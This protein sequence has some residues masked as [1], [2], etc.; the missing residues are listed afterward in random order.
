MA[1]FHPVL[2]NLDLEGLVATYEKQWNEEALAYLETREIAE[3]TGAAFR[4]G[5][6]DSVI[7][8]AVQKA[9]ASGHL[10]GRIVFPVRDPQGKLLDLIGRSIDDREPKYKALL[11]VT[12]LL[13][14]APV[15]E[16]AEDVVLAGGL[17]DVLSL[18]Q[19][20]FPAVAVPDC[21]SFHKELVPLFTG[22][23]VFVCYG[24]DEEGRR[25]SERVA[26][27]LEDVADGVYVVTLP[28]GIKDINDLYVRAENAHEVFQSL[29]HRAVQTTHTSGMAPDAHYL[30]VY[31]EEYM[32]RFRGQTT[33][34]P[35]GLA[36]LDA[37]LIGGLRPGLYVIRG[38]VG[39][40]KTTLARQIAD[41]AAGNGCPVAFY[42]WG[43]SAYE[44]WANS[45]S[46]ILGVSVRDVLLGNL[47]PDQVKWANEQY[48][49]QAANMWTAEGTMN[50]T[51]DDITEHIQT[52]AGTI[53]KMP[54]VFLDYLQRIPFDTEQSFLPSEERSC[55][56]AYALHQ[57]AREF[58]CPVVVTASFVRE[59]TQLY[60]AVE[61]AA[62]VLMTLT[63]LEE[64][65]G[66]MLL[67]VEKNRNGDTGALALYMDEKPA[68]FRSES[69]RGR[70]RGENEPDATTA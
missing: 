59:G 48:Q 25:E 5:Y 49:E 35:T 44:L 22:K 50:T 10:V 45:L 69:E 58:N 11:G 66:Q 21:H 65:S 27:L 9:N 57:I 62:D 20:Q 42:S 28:E 19:V 67:A 52:I 33:G 70:N 23:R 14:N 8:F 2:S 41:H 12:P 31:N 32:K 47:D 34:V 30:T 18:A 15:L 36:E 7:G 26:N 39:V 24:N 13:F 60:E 3:K 29:I 43:A 63:E 4:L 17:F 6:E 54:T 61:A 68:H 37:L 55:L 56:V 16:E 1:K 40:G 53:G 64:G 46:R 38:P 51:L